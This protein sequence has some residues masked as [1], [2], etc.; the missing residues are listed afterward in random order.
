MYPLCNK[1]TV[2]GLEDLVAVVE[3]ALPPLPERL[4]SHGASPG[5]VSLDA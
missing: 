3:E 4:K 1:H 5:V 2:D